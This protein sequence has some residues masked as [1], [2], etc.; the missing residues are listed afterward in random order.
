MSTSPG[1]CWFRQDL[2]LH[3]NPALLAAIDCGEVLPVFILDDDNAGNWK[4]GSASRLW[5]HHS[6]NAL[7][8]SLEGRLSI[9]RGRA[10]DI[11]P[12]LCRDHQSTRVFW[13]RC[14]EPWRIERDK[15]IKK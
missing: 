11:I 2:R 7:Q 13:T 15:K 9:H 14:Y 1:I 6:L 8:K 10:E 5:L 4:C 3:D 12:R